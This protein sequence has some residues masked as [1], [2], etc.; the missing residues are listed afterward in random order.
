MR[1]PHLALIAAAA[2][3]A[4]APA[5]L[6]AQ[7]SSIVGTWDLFWETK[8]GPRQSGWMVFTQNGAR[9]DARLHGRGSVRARGTVSGSTFALRG[10]RLA[11]PYRIDGSWQGD[12]MEGAFKVLGVERRFTANRRR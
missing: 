7:A 1:P 5:L 10:T 3:V 2:L 6:H 11:V 4:S 12:R 8:R 9:L